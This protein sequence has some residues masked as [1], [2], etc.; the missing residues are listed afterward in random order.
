MKTAASLTLLAIA[1]FA[2]AACGPSRPRGPSDT[3][4]A[5]ALKTAPGAA[6]PSAIV[7]TEIAFARAAR[8]EGQWTA[9]GNFAAPGAVIHGRS[10]P[11]AAEALFAS[12]SDPAEP[13]QW[14]PRAVVMSCDGA[15]AISQGRFRNPQ[16]LVGNY[17]TVWERQA[18]GTYLWVYDVAGP[19]VPQP[20]PRPQFEDGDI[21]VTAI[22]AVEGL[23]A[24]CPRPGSPVP[25]PPSASP[26]AERPGDVRQSPDSTLRWRFEHRGTDAKYVVA[27][28][29]YEGAWVT[30]IE[31]SLASTP[32]G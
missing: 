26:L 10:G 31:E 20:P 17:V 30:A 6:Q 9:H 32:E 4:I 24:T 1:T 28:Y 13:V 8:E 21:V 16:G 22:D 5:R 27:E 15:L 11:V 29:H 3:V 19:D 18:D 23:V 7:K 12:L 25:P 2:L 14:G